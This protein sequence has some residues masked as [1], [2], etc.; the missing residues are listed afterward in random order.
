[1][2][3]ALSN[4]AKAI[5]LRPR[6]TNEGKPARSNRAARAFRVRQSRNVAFSLVSF[7]CHARRAGAHVCV[8]APMLR[9]VRVPQ[10]ATHLRTCTGAR[11]PV[12]ALLR[13]RRLQLL[14]AD[15]PRLLAQ[16]KVRIFLARSD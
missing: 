13:R 2:R 1:M 4:I 8:H 16:I 5:S 7:H 10:A 9:R 15:E 12:L 14:P 11:E 3:R 6:G